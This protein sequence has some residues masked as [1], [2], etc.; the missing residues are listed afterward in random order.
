MDPL[1]PDATPLRMVY[2]M[3]VELEKTNKTLERIAEALEERN[4]KWL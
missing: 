4:R 2:A 3:V 1:P